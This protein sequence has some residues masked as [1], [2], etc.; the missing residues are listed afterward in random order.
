[1]KCYYALKLIRVSSALS[2]I[3]IVFNTEFKCSNRNFYKVLM[4]LFELLSIV[5]LDT[6]KFIATSIFSWNRYDIW[7]LNAPP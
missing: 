6:D 7:T 2:P 4:C 3:K 5:E 1:M